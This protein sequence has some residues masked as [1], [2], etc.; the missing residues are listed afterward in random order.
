MRIQLPPLWEVHGGSGKQHGYPKEVP[1][2]YGLLQSELS[3][4][5]NALTVLI[6]TA[7]DFTK[8]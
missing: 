6:Q 7:T 1:D 4:S 5:Q 2:R 8:P 3:Y